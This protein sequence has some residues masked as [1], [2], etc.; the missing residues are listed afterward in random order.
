MV[1]ELFCHILRS[2]M[3]GAQAL[4][5]HLPPPLSGVSAGMLHNHLVNTE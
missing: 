1:V 4:D 3:G 5:S 2:V